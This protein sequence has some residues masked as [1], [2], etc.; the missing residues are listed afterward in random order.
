MTASLL[1]IPT[2]SYLGA[3]W[4]IVI[5]QALRFFILFALLRRYLSI[6]VLLQLIALPLLCVGI[7]SGVVFVMQDW[8]LW[9]VILSSM[10]VYIVGLLASGAVHQYEVDRLQ[11][12]AQ[13][14]LGLSLPEA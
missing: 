12:L 11:G 1:L 13:T 10:V 14:R 9:L 6:R 2:F 3:C 4:A 7:M 8:N 5:T